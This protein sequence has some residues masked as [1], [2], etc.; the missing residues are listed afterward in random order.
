M[1]LLLAGSKVGL[2]E[3]ILKSTKAAGRNSTSAG[4]KGRCK[5][6]PLS[7]Q[8]CSPALLKYP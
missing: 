5:P 1:H 2:M 7:L 4:N 6:H 3:R 8:C